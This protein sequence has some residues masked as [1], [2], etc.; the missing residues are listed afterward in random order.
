MKRYASLAA[1]LLL[2]V[3]GSAARAEDAKPF[4]TN[5]DVD[6]TM[7]LPPPPA[8][9]SAETKAELGEVLTMQVTRT[10]EMEARAIAD[11]EENVWRF[12]DVMGPNFN[13][14]KLPKFSAFFDRV[15]ETE[16]AVVDPAKDVWKRPRP[17][18]LSDLVKPV[19]KLSSSG[20]WPSGHATVGTMM[21]IILSD[22]VPEKRAQIMAR[23]AEFAHNRIVGG[24]H[25]PSD[26]EMGKISGSVIAA[27]LLNRE[28]FKAEYEVARAELRSDLG[29]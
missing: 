4:I 26:V 17:H 6:L 18:Q 2:L 15:V 7:I 24:I 28:D 23:A 21:G 13:K 8:N 19:V 29:M 27:V 1:G 11:A 20:S 16:G 12:A 25:Y 10:P 3:V 9:D 22:M 5:K 14:D